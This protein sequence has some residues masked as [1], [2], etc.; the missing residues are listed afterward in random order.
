MHK[1]PGPNDVGLKVLIFY[2]VVKGAIW[3]GLALVLASGARFG[4]AEELQLQ[5]ERLQGHL[6]R[7]WSLR[8]AESLLDAAT[9]QHLHVAG[10]ALSADGVLSLFEGWALHHRRPWAPW[11]VVIASGIFVPFE[12]FELMKGI[13]ITRV[14]V[15]AV[16]IA[17]VV[18]LAR[19]IY[20]EHVVKVE[21]QQAGAA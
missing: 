9:R 3:L 5:I 21:Q 1:A 4:L 13:K 11:L 17:V 18:Y 16:N 8:L 15:F 14:V 7:A 2:K 12:V 20:R 10:L 6:S 19:R